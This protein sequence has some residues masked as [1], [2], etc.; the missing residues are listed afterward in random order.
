[1]T[2]SI[3]LAVPALAEPPQTRGRAAHRLT[4]MPWVPMAVIGL[5]VVAAI[6]APWLTPYN[7]TENDLSQQLIPPAWADGGSTAH[8]L[9]TDGFGRDVS[10][11]LLYG[12]R[13]SLSVAVVSLVIAIV[14]S[15]VVGVTA[16]F[17]GGWIDSVLMRFADVVNTVP[18]L[19]LALVLA[20][21]IGP[22]FVMVVTVLG[23]LIWPRIARLIRGETL[24]IRKTDFIRYSQAIGVSAFRV[25]LW[26]VIRNILPTLL[27]AMT[28]EI[29]RVIILEASLSFLGAGIPP[30]QA[31][32]GV[33]IA[34]G[35]A[36]VATGWWVALVPGLAITLVVLAS[37]AIGDWLRDRLDPR[38][39]RRT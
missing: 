31:S 35:R 9:G 21:W 13:V 3:K 16:G 36:L 10:T 27:V 5:F 15:T 30:P 32:W 38:V 37:N 29:G 6:A 8:L 1:M 17:A 7:P 18:T 39:R 14:I 24:V 19:M 11:R 33:M 4:L 12:G 23:L 25:V 20:A 2:E 28:L 26:H 34:D 22:S